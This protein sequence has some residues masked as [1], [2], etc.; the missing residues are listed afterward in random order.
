M[1]Q[2]TVE[3]QLADGINMQKPQHPK[4]ETFYITGL[5]YEN[6]EFVFAHEIPITV[7]WDGE[8]W[9]Y[10]TGEYGVN[11]FALD[12]QEANFAYRQTFDACWDN[13]ACAKDNELAQ[14]AREMKAALN[15]L[16]ATI[17]PAL[18]SQNKMSLLTGVR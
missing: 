8:G 10:E 5:T 7:A 11:G 2:A 16:V 6:R 12:Q 14:S 15:S 17:V 4:I 18:P 3:K 9:I 1:I 13:I